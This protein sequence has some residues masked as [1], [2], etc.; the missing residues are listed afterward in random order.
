MTNK[1]VRE[2]I[3]KVQ[4][5]LTSNTTS[6]PALVYNEDRTVLKE[7]PITSEMMQLFPEGAVKVYV[8]GTIDRNGDIDLQQRVKDQD[9]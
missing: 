5:P 7:I 2:H 6:P 1:V 9:W 8:K 3:F 4:V